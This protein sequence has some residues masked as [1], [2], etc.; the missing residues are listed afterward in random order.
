M[1]GRLALLVLGI[2]SVAGAAVRPSEE[3]RLRCM[4]VRQM[5]LPQ[6]VMA[7]RPS[8]YVGKFSIPSVGVDVSCYESSEQSVVDARD[9]AAYFYACDHWIIADHV[10]QGFSAIKRCKVGDTALLLTEHGISR[11]TCVGKIQG[12]NTGS[13]LTDTDYKPIDGMYPNSLVCYTCNDNWRNVT[14][15]FFEPE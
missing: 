7:E 10:H 14:I 15:V 5:K 2:L 13:S 8:N 9:S 4:A 6:A 3:M 11:Y 12:H 1:L